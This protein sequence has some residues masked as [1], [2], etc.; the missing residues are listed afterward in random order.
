M[1]NKG[2]TLIEM[3]VVI[4]IIGIL[5]AVV[6][7]ALGPS[8]NKAKDTRIISAMNQVRSLAETKFNPTTS[9]YEDISGDTTYGQLDADVFANT[10]VNIGY[11]VT[12]GTSYTAFAPL[13]TDANSI[14][15]VDSTGF[16]GIMTGATAPVS[17]GVS[18]Q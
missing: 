7:T 5:A 10:G 3:L 2:F 11:D 9:V 18:C 6:L 17:A 12:P 1:K 4:G 16:G 15:C 14:Y 8:R 13:A